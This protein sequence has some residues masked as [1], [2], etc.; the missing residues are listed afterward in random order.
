[1]SFVYQEEELE[2]KIKDESFKFRQPSA[3]EQKAMAKKFREADEQ[4]EAVDIYIDFFVSLGLPKEVLEKMSLKGLL[5]LF[6]YTVG[7]KKN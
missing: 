2:L 1:V 5:D 7:S 4:T 6:A 3:Y